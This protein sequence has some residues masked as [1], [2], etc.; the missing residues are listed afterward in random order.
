MSFFLYLTFKKLEQNYKPLEINNKV[1][2][3][4]FLSFNSTKFSYAQLNIENYIQF[5]LQDQCI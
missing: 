4:A 5:A 1:K 3:N 2:L